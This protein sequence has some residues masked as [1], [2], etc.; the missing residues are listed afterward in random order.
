MGGRAGY[1][2]NDMADQQDLILRDI[3]DNV[4]QRPQFDATGRPKQVVVV[5]FT[6]PHGFT[7]QVT[8]PL[9]DWKDPETRFRKVTE[10]VVDLEGPFWE[11]GPETPEEG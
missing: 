6:T 10:A 8:I 5:S 7:G 9:N 4:L 2:G 11:T 1:K 3:I